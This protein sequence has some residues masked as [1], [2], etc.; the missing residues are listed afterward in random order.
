MPRVFRPW[1]VP[2]LTVCFGDPKEHQGPPRSA[3]I[4]TASPRPRAKCPPTTQSVQF[5]PS[6]L[7]HPHPHNYTPHPHPCLQSLRG[8][9]VEEVEQILMDRLVKYIA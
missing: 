7:K 9:S 6:C 1:P 8:K 4:S 3:C 5:A 2:C